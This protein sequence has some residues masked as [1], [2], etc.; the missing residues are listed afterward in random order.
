MN[1]VR[2]IIMATQAWTMPPAF[3]HNATAFTTEGQLI[4]HTGGIIDLSDVTT[5]TSR[6]HAPTDTCL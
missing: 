6:Y 4:K 1:S 2:H 5:T 3:K